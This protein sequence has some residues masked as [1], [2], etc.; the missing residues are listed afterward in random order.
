M[1]KARLA[2][3]YFTSPYDSLHS[4]K[5]W[6][7]PFRRSGTRVLLVSRCAVRRDSACRSN[8]L[9][10]LRGRTLGPAVAT[11]TYGRRPPCFRWT[12]PNGT[13]ECGPGEREGMPVSSSQIDRDTPYAMTLAQR[14]WS[15]LRSGRR[16][17]GGNRRVGAGSAR[18]IFQVAKGPRVTTRSYPRCSPLAHRRRLAVRGLGMG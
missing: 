16:S 15:I 5:V 11:L 12:E 1:K 14:F 17:E 10:L 18:A 4:T 13:V 8:G 9:R 2:S 3:E 6:T 7:A